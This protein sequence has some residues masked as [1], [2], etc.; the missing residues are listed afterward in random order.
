[1]SQTSTAI[2]NE[3]PGIST[4]P[5]MGKMA[6]TEAIIA[7]KIS[8]GL[9]WQDIA[10]HYIAD[11]GLVIVWLAQCLIIGYVLGTG[12]LI[13]YLNE[14]SEIRLGLWWDITIKFVTPIVLVV[15]LVVNIVKEA[16]DPYGG[17]PWWSLLLG[18]WG[19]LLGLGIL[20]YIL[21]KKKPTQYEEEEEA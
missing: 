8:K 11:F 14:I 3:M 21:Y 16:R 6:M 10:D 20:G 19:V 15:I 4:S 9:S 7:A 18:G 13:K 17:Y 2:A 5:T 12:R 1:M